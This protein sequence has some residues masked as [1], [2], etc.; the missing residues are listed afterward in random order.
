MLNTRGDRDSNAV[1]DAL[2]TWGPTAIMG[3]IVRT[4]GVYI[5]W[6]EGSKKVEKSGDQHLDYG[7]AIPSISLPGTTLEGNGY[8]EETRVIEGVDTPAPEPKLIGVR[9]SD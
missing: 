5:K 8:G 7:D 9:D 1:S 6:H 4:R 3:S 2:L